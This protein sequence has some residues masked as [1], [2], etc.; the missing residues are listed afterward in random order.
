MSDGSTYYTNFNFSLSLLPHVS[1]LE[2]V[3]NMYSVYFKIKKVYFIRRKKKSEKKYM[4]HCLYIQKK[5]R[6][7]Y[8]SSS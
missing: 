3:F 5:V 1:R 7:P 4:H 6:I 2:E 8:L